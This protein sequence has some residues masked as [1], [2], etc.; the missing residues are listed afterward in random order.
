MPEQ[1]SNTPLYREIL[2]TKG[3]KT[4]VDTSDFEMLNAYSWQATRRRSGIYARR[5]VNSL[6]KRYIYMHRQILGLDHG[7]DRQGDHKMGNTLDNRRQN[8]RIATR[9]QNKANS[10]RDRLAAS[11]F[12]GVERV[13]RR[14][15]IRYKAHIKTGGVTHQLGCFDCIEDAACAY[16]IKAQELFGEFALLNFSGLPSK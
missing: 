3:Y 15:G 4:I 9:S 12:R 10:R 13:Q 5:T 14:S 2:L 6:P 11:G 1:D 16:D 8:L 7:D